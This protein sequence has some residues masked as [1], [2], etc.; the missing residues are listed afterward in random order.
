MKGLEYIEE[1][2]TIIIH[3]TDKSSSLVNVALDS[4]IAL[5]KDVVG[6]I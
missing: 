2:D 4:G 3:Y 5:I 1:K 6:M